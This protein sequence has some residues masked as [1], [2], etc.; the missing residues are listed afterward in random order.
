[1]I[2]HFIANFPHDLFDLEL[3][4]DMSTLFDRK[5]K[6]E[7]IKFQEIEYKD[8]KGK[9][10]IKGYSFKTILTVTGHSALN[11]CMLDE[12]TDRWLLK[13]IF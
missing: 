7:R 11:V 10:N 6:A 2:I 1:M 12:K 5:M 9:Y 3:K 8:I 4:L 13:P